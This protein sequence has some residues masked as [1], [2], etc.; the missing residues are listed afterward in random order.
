MT[1][2]ASPSDPGYP[3][4]LLADRRT[5]VPKLGTLRPSPEF[6]HQL[7]RA[8]RKFS[9]P[10]FTQKIDNAVSSFVGMHQQYA[11][12]LH[13]QNYP[14]D[15]LSTTASTV[16]TGVGGGQ[17]AQTHTLALREESDATSARTHQL[18]HLQERNF[19]LGSMPPGHPYSHPFSAVERPKTP[20][21]DQES[22]DENIMST[23]LSRVDTSSCVLSASHLGAPGAAG[24]GGTRGGLRRVPST[25]SVRSTGTRRSVGSIGTS[26]SMNSFSSAAAAPPRTPGVVVRGGAAEKHHHHQHHQSSAYSSYTY[27]G[28]SGSRHGQ[29]QNHPVL[30]QGGSSW[31]RG[32]RMN[33]KE[34]L[35]GRHQRDDDVVLH[36]SGANPKNSFHIWR[37]KQPREQRQQKT[38][39][40]SRRGGNLR[41]HQ[42]QMGKLRKAEADAARHENTMA[43]ESVTD[44]NFSY[45]EK[46]NSE[47]FADFNSVP[48]SPSIIVPCGSSC[49][50]GDADVD[51]LGHDEDEDD[52]LLQRHRN[53]VGNFI[54]NN[55]DDEDDHDFEHELALAAAAAEAGFESA[56]AL[57]E[58]NDDDLL[59]RHAGNGA[60]AT[61]H[62]LL[63][64]PQKRKLQVLQSDNR[65]LD[66]MNLR[67]QKQ[68]LQLEREKLALQDEVKVKKN[69][70][71]GMLLSG[72]VGGTAGAGKETRNPA[73]GGAGQFL[74]LPGDSDCDV[75]APSQVTNAPPQGKDQAPAAAAPCSENPGPQRQMKHPPPLQVSPTTQLR[76]M[77]EDI[78]TPK[79]GAFYSD[80][81]M[82]TSEVDV[83]ENASLAAPP[84]VLP[85]TPTSSSTAA[86]GG[87]AGTIGTGGS[88]G[89]G[90]RA[91]SSGSSRPSP[92]GSSTSTNSNGGLSGNSGLATAVAAAVTPA[93]SG[94]VENVDTAVASGGASA[95]TATGVDTTI[96]PSEEQ[97]QQCLQSSETV[98]QLHDDQ[99]RG[100]VG[101][102]RPRRE[103]NGGASDGTTTPQPGDVEKDKVADAEIA[104]NSIPAPAPGPHHQD[105]LVEQRLRDAEHALEVTRKALED[106]E[107]E[108]QEKSE[109]LRKNDAKVDAKILLDALESKTRRETL[110]LERRVA[111]FDEEVGKLRAKYELEV[112][113]W[114]AA[115]MERD[116]QLALTAAEAEKRVGARLRAQFAVEKKAAVATAVQIEGH[117]R[118]RAVKEVEKVWQ[119]KYADLKKSREESLAKMDGEIA[120]LQGML[121]NYTDRN[122]ER[123]KRLR[124]REL[125]VV[126]REAE[127]AAAEREKEAVGGSS[128]YAANYGA[129]AGVWGRVEN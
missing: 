124:S 93:F 50:G 53:D 122:S 42:N 103:G 18:G 94:R 49:V 70:T 69:N 44:I 128:S 17:R 76:G 72:A 41:E 4:P 24:A 22:R 2:A 47:F 21:A 15:V 64:S 29:T 14:P 60:G 87:A 117:K 104:G 90:G 38:P 129:D 6:Q 123:N 48:G 106:R 52:L 7:E 121:K 82:L 58:P 108:L 1:K 95:S 40:R 110:S 36:G 45:E 109:Q 30:D 54:C 113:E 28:S 68:I 79:G 20:G 46:S 25:G 23:S 84:V 65:K 3:K 33:S 78:P 67:F 61:D 119:D 12:R 75:V 13:Q 100:V 66:E 99:V 32:A 114:K 81:P 26:S 57:G 80:N 5:Q 16:G 51:F 43:F 105:R 83:I 101:V 27:G 56:L 115:V 98:K 74:T 97:E 111:Q 102:A 11:D 92:T 107:R 73:A 63:L 86:L 88:G 55:E 112:E 116:A 85:N 39:A 62:D 127:L 118:E 10:E 89:G 34:R 19:S 9:K 91:H 71:P 77:L 59:L 125:K 31:E 120:G 37:Q 35:H 8:L 126:A 96:L